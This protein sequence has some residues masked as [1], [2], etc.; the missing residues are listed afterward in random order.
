LI[1]SINFIVCGTNHG[2][3]HVTEL[4][5]ATMSPVSVL[6]AIWRLDN[7]FPGLLGINRKIRNNPFFDYTIKGRTVAGP[8]F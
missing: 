6:A 7:G 2:G 8:A 4:T 1:L 5:L 3:G